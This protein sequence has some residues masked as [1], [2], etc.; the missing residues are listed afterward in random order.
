VFPKLYRNA[1]GEL[2][3]SPQPNGRTKK[4]G[5]LEESPEV[6]IGGIPPVGATASSN[7]WEATPAAA[8]QWTQAH[9]SVS[10]ASASYPLDEGD[11]EAEDLSDTALDQF[12]ASLGDTEGGP[13]WVWP[14]FTDS[15]LEL[16]LNADQSAASNSGPSTG[17]T[18]DGSGH[19][20]Q[21]TQSAQQASTNSNLFMSNKMVTA[22]A[23]LEHLPTLYDVSNIL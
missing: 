16:Q 11:P 8:A 13:G 21:N 4:L 12:L 20:P 9:P 3:P 15:A 23:V 19:G 22:A 10:S 17:D 14:L 18:Y 7:P 1:N 6:Y 2:V 5:R